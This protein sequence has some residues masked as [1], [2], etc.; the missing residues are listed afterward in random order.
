MAALEDL[1]NCGFWDNKV[2]AYGKDSFTII[3]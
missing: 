2:S 3:L 1:V